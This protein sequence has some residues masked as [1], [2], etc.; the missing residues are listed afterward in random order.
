MRN[1][2][3]EVIPEQQTEPQTNTE[4]TEEKP[5]GTLFDTITYYKSSDLDNFMNGMS[6]E[7]A[8]YCLL[9]ACQAAYN[10]KAYTLV[11]SE[12]L[13]KALRLLTQE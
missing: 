5:Q 11:E 8:I 2:K 13:S 3:K 12:L 6:K 9:Q 1:R 10:R 4:T 7:Q